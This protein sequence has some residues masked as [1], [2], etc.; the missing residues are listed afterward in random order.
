[1]T[2][3]TAVPVSQRL[4]DSPMAMQQVRGEARIPTQA[5]QAQRWALLSHLPGQ[6][7]TAHTPCPTI[8]QYHASYSEALDA[9]TNRL[10]HPLLKHPPWLPTTYTQ[11]PD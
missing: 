11:G 8:I 2:S 5:R 7:P 10:L 1:M 9:Q 4:S 3:D 6:V